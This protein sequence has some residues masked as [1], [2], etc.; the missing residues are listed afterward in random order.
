MTKIKLCVMAACAVALAV[1]FGSTT[2]A[3]QGGDAVKMHIDAAKQSAGTMWAQLQ[4]NLCNRAVGM[5]APDSPQNAP[6]QPGAPPPGPPPRSVWYG[7]PAKVFDNVYVFSTKNG[8]GGTTVW[9]INTSDGIVLIDTLW[10]YAIKGEVEDGLKSFGLNPANIKAA[11]ITHGHGD[12]F[13]GAKYLQEMYS[14]KIYI[15]A[16]DWD[17]ME[18]QAKAAG[19]NQNQPL[20]KKDLTATDGQKFTLG[21]TTLTVYITPGHTQGTLSFIF[22]VKINGVTHMAALWGGTA[23]SPNTGTDNLKQYSASVNRF[24]DLVKQNKV[25]VMLSNHNGFGQY[26]GKISAMKPGAPNPFVVGTDGV[27]RFL[28]VLDHCAQANFAAAAA[29]KK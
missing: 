14:S 16:P 29:Q 15:S 17:L 7:A 5:E 19:G 23:I 6:A 12:H 4:A 26:F 20:F 27:L 13:G 2:P 24:M 11:F 21:D 8:W 22:P 18:R 25:D 3:A 28:Q 10:D 9:A 1:A